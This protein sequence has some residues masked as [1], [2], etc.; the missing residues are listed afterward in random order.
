[1]N[2][3]ADSIGICDDADA[4]LELDVA[5][6]DSKAETLVAVENDAEE[7]VPSDPETPLLCD[8]NT[9]TL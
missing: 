5:G 6:A 4:W 3:D 7:S 2:N 8:E 1:M 9:D